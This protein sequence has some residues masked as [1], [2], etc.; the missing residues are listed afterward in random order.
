MPHQAGEPNGA[1][2]RASDAH[3]LVVE[4][5]VVGEVKKTR[6]SG[7]VAEVLSLVIIPTFIVGLGLAASAKGDE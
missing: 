6:R 2:V 4:V 7:V 1:A 5:R 3:P